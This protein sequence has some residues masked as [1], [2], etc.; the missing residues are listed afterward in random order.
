MQVKMSICFIHK[1]FVFGDFFM[2]M[3]INV[4]IQV[5]DKKDVLDTK[6]FEYFHFISQLFVHEPLI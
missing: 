2:F 5:I 1:L 4:V 6:C 3:F